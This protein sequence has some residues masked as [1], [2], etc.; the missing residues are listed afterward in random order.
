MPDRESVSSVMWRLDNSFK[1]Y[2]FAVICSVVS[3]TAFAQAAETVLK[4]P[5][6]SKL[7]NYY[8]SIGDYGKA[9]SAYRQAAE[10]G[11]GWAMIG[12]ADMLRKGEGT[13]ADPQQAIKL[14]EQASAA[15]LKG[16]AGSKLGNYYRSIGDYGKALSAYRQA[17]EAGEGWAMIGLADM[18][19]K[20]EGTHV[21]YDMAK[22]LLEAAVKRESISYAYV[23]L[24]ALAADHYGSGDAVHYTRSLLREAY[25]ADETIAV[26]SFNRMPRNS[27]VA[28]IQSILGGAAFYAGPTDG[29]LTRGTLRGIRRF[30]IQSSIPDCNKEAMPK[31]LLVALLSTLRDGNVEEYFKSGVAGHKSAARRKRSKKYVETTANVKQQSAA[32]AKQSLASKKKKKSKKPVEAAPSAKPQTASVVQPPTSKTKRK[33]PIQTTASAKQ[34]SPMVAQS[35]TLKKKLKKP[36]ETTVSSSQ[37]STSGAKRSA[38]S[39]KPAVEARSLSPKKRTK[40]TSKTSVIPGKCY[41]VM[42]GCGSLS[43]TKSKKS[44]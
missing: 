43:R 42:G 12:L 38:V 39:A 6:G 19:R 28:V 5:A 22:A 21:N 13:T 14:L 2:L 25:A 37:Q 18:L 20:G 23:G 3:T 7:G 27:K 44:S 24:I 30:C 9:L 29:I 11:E 8:R 17:A 32:V 10:A 31:V 26:N 33:K 36:V 15:G 34:Q 4:G 40:E 16:P 1:L 41:V 35:P